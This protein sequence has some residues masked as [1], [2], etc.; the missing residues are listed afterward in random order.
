MAISLPFVEL[1]FD[2]SLE[3]L[4]TIAIAST[5]AG[6]ELTDEPLFFLEDLTNLSGTLDFCGGKDS[7][8]ESTASIELS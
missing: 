7:I 4:L 5:G 6:F 8:P 1:I 2:V 3:L